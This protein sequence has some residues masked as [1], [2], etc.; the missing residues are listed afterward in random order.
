MSDLT[1]ILYGWR[2]VRREACKV[3]P[4]RYI[5]KVATI[6]LLDE[7]IL[8]VVP[9]DLIDREITYCKLRNALREYICQS[10]FLLTNRYPLHGPR[11]P[12][13]N[14]YATQK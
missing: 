5:S 11:E 8:F 6:S 10:V 2:D 12:P 3:A 9:N 4:D 7:T 13:Y 14:L 1:A